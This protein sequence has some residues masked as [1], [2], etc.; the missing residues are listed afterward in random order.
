MLARIA[1]VLDAAGRTPRPERE[2]VATSRFP[3]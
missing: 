1:A 2:Y 3:I